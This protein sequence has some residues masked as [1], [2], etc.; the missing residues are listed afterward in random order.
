MGQ[1]YQICQWGIRSQTD[2]PEV[3]NYFASSDYVVF[4]LDSGI[5]FVFLPFGS[6]WAIPTDIPV[7]VSMLDALELTP[8]PCE[9]LFHG[10]SPECARV[11]CAPVFTGPICIPYSLP[12]K[13]FFSAGSRPAL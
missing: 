12:L 7:F 10:F 4:A 11:G 2:F 9:D 8:F 6:W 1:I 3:P 13:L 5:A